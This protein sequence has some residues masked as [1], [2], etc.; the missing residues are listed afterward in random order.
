MYEYIKLCGDFISVSII[1]SV[2]YGEGSSIPKKKCG[3]SEP[4]PREG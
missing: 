3:I 4:G 1:E 2:D